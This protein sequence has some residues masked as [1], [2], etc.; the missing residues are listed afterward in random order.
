MEVFVIT[1]FKK[2]KILDTQK[3]PIYAHLYLINI[4]ILLCCFIFE[5]KVFWMQ[6]K[7]PLQS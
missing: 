3:A 6:L 7:L 5:S 2:R 1:I 4:N